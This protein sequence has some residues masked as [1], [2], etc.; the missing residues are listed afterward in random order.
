M[1]MRNTNQII[2]IL[3]QKLKANKIDRTVAG[4]IKN[5][6]IDAFNRASPYEPN[7]QKLLFLQ[8]YIN[9]NFITAQ[10]NSAKRFV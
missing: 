7:K 2:N 3:R 5:R 9:L 1:E 10:K 8:K 6:N 4:W